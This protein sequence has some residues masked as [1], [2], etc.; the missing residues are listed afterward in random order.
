MQIIPVH[1]ALTKAV[2]D[3]KEGIRPLC[4][5]ERSSR[6]CQTAA[7]A[8]LHRGI[9]IPGPFVDTAFPEPTEAPITPPEGRAQRSI[10]FTHPKALCVL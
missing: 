7:P 1:V 2:F 4:E 6:A 10:R 9:S 8:P 3:H 5:C